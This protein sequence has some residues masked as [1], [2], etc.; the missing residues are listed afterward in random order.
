M[1]V[2][3]ERCARHYGFGREQQDD[4][5]RRA[6]SSRALHAQQTGAFAAEIV[7][8]DPYSAMATPASTRTNNRSRPARSGSPA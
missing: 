3:A 6:R 7:G 5:A 8:V 1:G 2:F 4:Y